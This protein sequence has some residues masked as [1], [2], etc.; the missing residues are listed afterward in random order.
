[1]LNRFLLLAAFATTSGTAWAGDVYKWVDEN[2]RTQYGESVPPTYRKIATKVN[3][4]APEP[5]AAQRREAE[6][7]AASDQARAKSTA[8]KPATPKAK[9]PKNP[10]TEPPPVNEADAAARQCEAERKKYRESVACFAPYRSNAGT[11]NPEAF[12]HCVEVKEPTC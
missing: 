6:A 5:T 2:G 10:R 11:I 3:V 7:R 12:Q 1:M 8:A 9:T 4:D